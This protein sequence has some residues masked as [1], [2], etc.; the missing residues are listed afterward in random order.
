MTERP[1]TSRL[2]A[3]RILFV[4]TYPPTRCGIAN[5]THSLVQAMAEQRRSVA[6][7]GVVRLLAPGE[8]P[9]PDPI[10]E[11][12]AGVSNSRWVDHVAKVA[13]SYDVVWLQ[14]EF[15]IYGESGDRA[16]RRLTEKV[17]TPIVTTLHTVLRE[18]DPIQ[19][20]LTRHL[21][22]RSAHTVVLSQAARRMLVDHYRVDPTAVEV[23]P[24]GVRYRPLGQRAP[25]G[26]PIIV[27]WGLLGP[28]KGIEWGIAAVSRLKHLDP[29]PHYVVA[30]ATHPQVFRTQGDAYRADL[31][32]LVRELDVKQMVRMEDTYLSDDDLERLLHSARIA[33][34]PYDSADQVSSGVLVEALGAGLP[35]VA[36]AFPHAVELLEDGAGI[37]VPHRDPQAMA[38]AISTLLTNDEAHGAARSRAA[39][40]GR[41]L[42]WSQVADRC[43]AIAASAS[44]TLLVLRR[45]TEKAARKGSPAPGRKPR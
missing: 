23:V 10:I 16:L 44:R 18:P 45:P 20:D 42:H 39:D 29:A 21:V 15:G 8:F 33:F 41:S 37:V 43:E 32:R 12:Y 36:T 17:T 2:A 5:Y 38:D 30:G 22:K 40:L 9:R 14:H 4:S 25:G 35:V 24:H 1:Q 26:R 6:D 28:G 3:P 27:T 19:R 13:R 7:L 11:A 31:V 34:L